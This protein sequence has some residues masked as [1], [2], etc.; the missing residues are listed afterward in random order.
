MHSSRN[1][2]SHRVAVM[3]AIAEQ[4]LAILRKKNDVSNTFDA[5]AI[6][7]I[8]C[9]SAKIEPSQY[10]NLVAIARAGA[11]TNTINVA[12]ATK[13]GIPV[14]NTPGE[15]ANSV[16]ELVWAVAGEHAR[17]LRD[18]RAF[19]ARLEAMG[20]KPEEA[21][22]WNL[23]KAEKG[24]RVGSELSGKTLG[25]IGLGYIGRLIA[26]GG[27]DRNMTVFGCDP[28]LPENAWLE[29][30]GSVRKTNLSELLRRSDFVSLHIPLSD[31]TTRF[32]G[33]KEVALMRKG[34]V[35]I[36]YARGR[37]VDDEAVIAAL[38]AG[39]LGQYL[40]DLTDPPSLK[41]VLHPKVQWTEHTGAGTVESEDRCA[42]SAA[43]Y[44][45]NF[46]R[47]GIV[48]N[49]VN[50]PRLDDQPD[51]SVRTRIC[52]VNEDMP[53]MISSITQ[54][55]GNAGLNITGLV[56]KSN[57]T[58]GYDVVDLQIP[59]DAALVQIIRNLPGVINTRTLSF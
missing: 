45:D 49:S 28:F 12:Q 57:G 1:P 37:L 26:R 54:V 31:S 8:I 59:V 13:R 3:D 16:Y 29:I 17:K 32:I 23:I 50:F 55:L 5:S 20:Q 7:A 47:F 25:V 19:R 43:T 30:D 41:L 2:S 34:A 39:H 14:F 22:L 58:I 9:R 48:E 15:N 6:T 40:T 44:L 38:D 35:L 53:N 56:N 51:D 36:N 33:S 11:G 4:G 10:P 21:E 18:S 24:K 46:L 27:L 52:V 42:V